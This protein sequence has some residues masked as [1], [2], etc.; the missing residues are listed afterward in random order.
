MDK[1]LYCWDVRKPEIPLIRLPRQTLTNQRFEFDIVGGR[2]LFSGDDKGSL[3]VFDLEK[4]GEKLS[5]NRI[6]DSPVV[7][8]SLGGGNRVLCGS[9]VRSFPPV[10]DDSDSEGDEIMSRP[11]SQVQWFKY[12]F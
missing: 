3:S 12:A 11:N 10:S 8:V 4:N 2:L 5:E 9:G 1:Y 7:S 6:S